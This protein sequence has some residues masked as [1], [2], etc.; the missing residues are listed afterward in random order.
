MPDK[1]I[2]CIIEV[3]SYF[4]FPAAGGKVQWPDAAA[5]R[6]DFRLLVPGTDKGCIYLS[7]ML[8]ISRLIKFISKCTRQ[9][10]FVHFKCLSLKPYE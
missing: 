9:E 1:R 2:G 6:G 5:G 7:V 8:P 10:I 4:I 3:K